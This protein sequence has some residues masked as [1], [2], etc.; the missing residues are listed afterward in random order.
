MELKAKKRRI[1]GKKVKKLR[2]EGSVPA[3]L[4]GGKG[5]P[6][7]LVLS[8]PEFERVYQEAGESTLIDLNTDGKKEK[9]LIADVQHDPLGKLLHV[10]LQRIAAGERLT[11]TVAIKV[12]GESPI[13]KSGEGI[14]LT[15]L[16]EV[17]VECLPQDLPPEIKV[18]VS[19]L[20]EIGKGIT[21]KD[22]PIDQTK[23]EILG[24]EPEELV[25]KIDFPQM[26]EEEEVAPVPEEAAVAAVE[27][28]E[29]KPEEEVPEELTEKERKP[30]PEEKPKEEEK[31]K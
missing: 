19:S 8:Q 25:L 29:E 1:Q 30:S 2:R 28:V 20:T 26:E 17:E 16:D 9:A 12:E 14:L 22:L 3:I 6:Q 7:P 18:D 21:V 4:Y 13:A 5:E 10:D 27:A 23:I 31:T 15:L 24:H 11:A